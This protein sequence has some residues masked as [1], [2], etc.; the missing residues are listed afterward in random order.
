VAPIGT[1]F[2]VF[3]TQLTPLGTLTRIIAGAVGVGT[4]DQP[5]TVIVSIV[6]AIAFAAWRYATIQRTTALVFT[7]IACAIAALRRCSAV[8]FTVETILGSLADAV[9]AAI[10]RGTVSAFRTLFFRVALAVTYALKTSL[11]C[12]T[13]AAYTILGTGVAV[14]ILLALPVIVTGTN[15]LTIRVIAVGDTI[16]VIVYTIVAGLSR[17]LAWRRV[18]AINCTVALVFIRIACAVPTFTPTGD[19]EIR[20]AESQTV[21][22]S[23]VG[24]PE[25]AVSIRPAIRSP[26][27]LAQIRAFIV[28][29]SD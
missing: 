25:S 18:T 2:A 27:V 1:T 14:F 21:G 24:N 28:V 26:A 23:G 16:T 3:T 19:T 15:R 4:V 7:R 22:V 8:N 11:T 29:P 13:L 10:A 20:H 5:I 6:G 12:P 17:D 9:S